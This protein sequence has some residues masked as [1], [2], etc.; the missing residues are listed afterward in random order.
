MCVFR[1]WLLGYL[2]VGGVAFEGWTG[3]T[4][5]RRREMGRGRVSFPVVLV[6]GGGGGGGKV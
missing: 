5:V 1:G 3:A 4:H 2:G 6:F